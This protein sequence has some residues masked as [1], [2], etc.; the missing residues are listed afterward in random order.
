MISIV[1]PI[2]N[3]EACL[4]LLYQRLTQV[5]SDWQDDYQVIIV[6]DGSSD[7][8]PAI[9][10]DIMAKDAHFGLVQLSRTFGHQGAISAGV[11]FADG[12]AVIIMDGDLQDP[13]EEIAT[14][15]AKWREGYDVVYAIRT[16][17]QESQ[18]KQL[19]YMA[20]YRCL[21]VV[22]EIPIPMDSGDFCLLDRKVATVLRR[23]LPESI[24]FVRGLR[25][26]AG[27]KQVGVDC[28]RDRRAAGKA[29]YTLRGLF[30]LAADGIFGFST[31]PL[32]LATYLG[33]LVALTSFAAGVFFVLHRMIGFKVLGHSPRENPGIATL[34]VGMFFL[35]GVILFFLGMLG[36][37]IG[38]IYVEVKR[39]PP[40]VVEG[41]Y[42]APF[43]RHGAT[44]ATA[45]AGERVT[46]I[47][48]RMGGDRS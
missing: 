2:L 47:L 29:K 45:D 11:S 15:L 3:E 38:R 14:L 19:L 5:A 22:S 33:L 20:F 39:R 1:I 31:L 35:G 40:F 46:A 37:Y 23:E 21:S 48:P 13:P 32:R 16:T 34:A 6:D 9:I 25:A 28:E 4:P 24:R 27:F 8:S 36:E 41:V 7:Q 17:R 18:I 43:R 12:D 44:H 10:T 30:R 42:G 26:Y